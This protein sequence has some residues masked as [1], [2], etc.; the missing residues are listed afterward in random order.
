MVPCGFSS[1]KEV[2]AFDLV[3]SLGLQFRIC[4][5]ELSVQILGSL[6]QWFEA[7]LCVFQ[8][9]GSVIFCCDCWKFESLPLYGHLSF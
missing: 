6:D 7:Y 5:F 3:P 2:R 9:R 8:F 4:K 1:A